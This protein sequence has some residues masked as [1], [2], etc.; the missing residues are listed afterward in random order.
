MI[1]SLVAG[2]SRAVSLEM[3]RR[4]LIEDLFRRYNRQDLSN[5]IKE[6]GVSEQRERGRQ[7]NQ[8]GARICEPEQIEWV[9]VPF[10]EAACDSD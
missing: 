8:S 5:E 2:G 1:I 3:K 9:V 4:G 7:K 10:N 6:L